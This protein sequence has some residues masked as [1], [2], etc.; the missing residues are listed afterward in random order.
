MA[1]AKLADK[2]VMRPKRS[3]MDPPVMDEEFLLDDAPSVVEQKSNFLH[4]CR[5]TANR[6][7]E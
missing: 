1:K 2:I 5:P 6:G 4:P 3:F 7:H